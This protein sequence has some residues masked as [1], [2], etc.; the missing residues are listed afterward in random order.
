MVIVAA[1]VA[2]AMSVAIAPAPAAYPSAARSAAPPCSMYFVAAVRHG[3]HAGSTYRGVLRMTLDASGRLAHGTLQLIHGGRLG[4][5]RIRTSRDIG[6]RMVTHA[7]VLH[8]IGSVN[9]RLRPCVGRM[10]GALKGPGRRDRGDWLAASGQ[11]IELPDGSIFI[12]APT[13]HVVYRADNAL[14]APR[15]FAGAVNTPGNVDGSRLQARMNM[16]GGIAFDSASS[17]LYIADVG[18]ATIRR[19]VLGSGQMTTTL[20]PSAA[21]AAAQA[22]GYP[23]VTAWEPQGL[24]IGSGGAVFITDARNYVVWK[25][26]P[27]TQQLKLLAG[28]PGTPGNADG[29]DTTVRFTGPQRIAVSSNGLISVAD[30]ISQRLRIRDNGTWSTLSSCC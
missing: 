14:S 5:Q 2:I 3:P 24:A 22:A 16:P 8:G 17:T 10:T 26:S 23:G 6:F 11:T 1:L 13:S 29:S 7:G 27:A 15:V 21:V 12:T 30:V 9:G 4:V 20:R 25:Y 28:R 18:N 19:L